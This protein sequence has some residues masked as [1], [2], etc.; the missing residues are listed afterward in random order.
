MNKLFSHSCTY[1][2]LIA[3][4]QKQASAQSTMFRGAPDHNY[5]VNAKVA[6]P[7]DELAWKFDAGA[8]VRSTV[9]NFNS[10]IFFG[11]SKGIFY[12]LN[13]LTG[14][15]NWAFNA[16]MAINSSAALHNGNVFFS[17]NRQTLYSLNAATGK[18]NFKTALGQSKSYEWAF[19][20]YYSSPAVVNDQIFI[21]SKDGC[22][23]DVNEISGQVK[24]KFKTGGIVRSSP[25]VAGGVLY[26]GDT[27]G[28][29]FAIDTHNGRQLWRFLTVG[30]GLKNEDFGY[31]R[32]AIIASPVVTGDK[33]IVGGRDGFLYA[34][35]KTSGKELW[36]MDH[37]ISWVIS[38]VAVKGDIVVTG[39][40][41]G[42]FVQ[43]IDLATGKQLWKF[44]THSTVWSSPVIDGDKVYVGS[45][46]GVLFCLDL[47]TG[48]K[49]NGFQAGDIIFSSPVVAGSLLYFGCDD[50][51][52][53]A[54]KPGAPGYKTPQTAKKYVF[55]DSEPRY[56]R[57]GTDI[58]IKQYLFENGYTVLDK[59]KLVGF[60]KQN[61][62]PVNSVIVFA[63]NFF[64]PEIT[65]GTDHS[66][67]R[68]YLNGGGKVVVT[69]INPVLFKFDPKDKSLSLRSYFFAD[70]V[71]SIKY[72]PDD[73]RS[74]KG[75]QPAFPTKTGMEWGLPGFW[76]A[77]LS[78]PANQVDIVLGK[79]ENG[80]ASAWVKKFNPAPGSGFVQIWV[81]EHNTDLTSI[82][83]VAEYELQ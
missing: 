23:Y 64:P 8:P 19:D 62:S 5:A 15:V 54:L 51:Y 10:A 42:R 63:T 37:K 72:G 74:Y 53:Y 2:L 26:A 12:S 33:V 73:L 21:G 68:N 3:L 11:S 59:E 75:S 65:D 83:R 38:T 1:L 29:L 16:G 58:K 13:K 39:T 77:P 35:D 28:S 48:S 31:D 66:L 41:D 80:L 18:L 71:L 40:S 22:I 45:Q 79:D 76:V 30:H 57:F 60:L 46:E 36:R 69:N 9:A 55:W 6:T 24:W 32:R 56:F 47:K 61:D 49:I 70:S 4:F 34:V 44:H 43:A 82:T 52:L 20:Y 7:F 67:L 27:D 14:K 17:D 50:G 81:N 25:A 78:L